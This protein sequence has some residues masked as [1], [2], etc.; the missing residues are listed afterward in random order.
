MRQRQHQ[1]RGPAEGR[2]L[3]QHRETLDPTWTLRRALGEGNDTVLFQGR[4]VHVAGWADRFLFDRGQLDRPLGTFSGG[5]QARVLIARL[6]LRPADLLL[7]DEPTNDLDL[8]TLQVLESSLQDFP[9]AVVL[10][11][12]DRWL[13][14]SVS[15]RL[16]AL[17]G[18]GGAEIYADL[19]QWQAATA[20]KAKG[21]GAAG[22]SAPAPASDGG[23][24]AGREGEAPRL[25]TRE[26]KELDGMEASLARAEGNLQKAQASLEDPAVA[27][28]VEEL[29]VRQKAVDAARIAVEAVYARWEVLE[30][31]NRKVDNS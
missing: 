22:R 20:S 1:A 30:K 9:G 5:E 15:Q 2:D 3:D 11:T 17:D 24:E 12:H 27:T 14:E 23:G 8:E 25:S 29:I 31:K 28:D 13:L 4:S 26:R 16:L 6:M 21:K 7:L 18:E 19:A 10:I